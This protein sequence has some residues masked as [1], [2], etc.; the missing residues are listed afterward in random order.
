[1]GII[2]LIT[3]P[4]ASYVGQ[5]T[6]SFDIRIREHISA[7]YR[8]SDGCRKLCEAI[9]K[10]G[11][12][13]TIFEILEI[14]DD[15][16][17]NHLEIYYIKLYNS[18][19]PN[20]YNLTRGGSGW[21]NLS[22]DAREEIASRLRKYNDYPVPMYVS[23]YIKGVVEGFRII[24][25]NC[26]TVIICSMNMSMDDKHKFAIEI[27]N[28]TPIEIIQFNQRR[29]LERNKINKN[30]AGPE[31]PLQDYFNY[32][33]DKYEGFTIRYPNCPEKKFNSRRVSFDQNYINALEYLEYLKSGGK[34]I[35]VIRLY[36]IDGEEVILPN[37]IQKTSKKYGLLVKYHN[38]DKKWFESKNSAINYKR[39]VDYLNECKRRQFND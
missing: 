19:Y 36:D 3:T 12:E 31:Y 2:Y 35:P 6:R 26:E 37:Y 39:A 21:P 20:G 13:Q 16:N 22:I 24:K 14:C 28:M 34:P 23:R 8:M 11:I 18:H 4:E 17:L 38:Y 32:L 33:P 5:T 15:K 30:D 29:Q 27:Y 1:M 9:R 10:F 25:P 7:A